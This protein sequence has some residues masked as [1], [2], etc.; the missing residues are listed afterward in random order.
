MSRLIYTD[1]QR[2]R[3]LLP[4]LFNRM[5][6]RNCSY[7][8]RKLFMSLSFLF[9]TSQIF[10]HGVQTAWCF[11]PNGD[12]IRIYIEHWH[13]PGQNVDCSAG[14]TIDVSVSINGGAATVYNNLS[15]NSNIPGTLATLPHEPNLPIKVIST[16][17][18]ANAYNNWGS[19]DFPIPAG[20]C[21]QGG[22]INITVLSA[23]DCVFEEVCGNLYPASTN[24]IITPA[25]CPCGPELCDGLDNDCDGFIDEGFDLDGDGFTTCQND[26]NDDN[27]SINP[28]ATEICDGID[29]NCDGFIDEGFTDTDG[30]SMAD[31]VDPDDDN[32]GTLDNLDCYP[33]DPIFPGT[34]GA[35]CNDGNT[36]TVNDVFSANGCSCTGTP[37]GL[38]EDFALFTTTG[39]V[40]NAGT[41]TVNGHVGANVGAISGFGLP[42]TLNGNV[43]SGDPATAQASIDVQFLYDQLLLT[44]PALAHPATYG[45]G[46]TVFPGTYAVASAG[47]LAGTI[48][49]N[50]LG[51]PD[52]VF[53]FKFGGA[54]TIGASSNVILSNGAQPCNV[55]WL[56]AGA[57]SIG[58]STQM[59]G[60]FISSPGAIT[61]ATGGILDGR[62]LSTTGAIA[63]SNA[64]VLAPCVPA[65][66]GT[67][68]DDGNPSTG[69]DVEDGFGNC[70][71]TQCPAAGATC[72]DGDAST[73]D[74]VE[75]G[76]CN[77]AGI[78]SLSPNL[79]TMANFALFTSTGALSNAGTSN[80]WGDVGTNAGAVAGFGAPTVLGGVIHAANATTAAGVIDLQNLS[81]QLLAAPSTMVHAPAFGAGE[82]LAPGVY[83]TA[84][85]GSVGGNLTLDGQG[86]SDA[87]FVF[88][89]GGAFTTGASATVMLIDGAQSCNVY[90]ISVGAIAM[91]TNTTMVGTIISG[92]GA[93]SMAVGGILEGRLLTTSGAIAVSGA[94]ITNNCINNNNNN[95]N[96]AVPNMLYFHALKNGIHTDID[97]MMAKDENVDFYEVEV[98]TDGNTF[99]VMEETNSERVNSPRQYELVDM[100][101]V[102]GENYYRLKVNQ[103]DGTYFYSSIRKVNFD[104]DFDNVILYPN[105][106][107]ENIYID[108][109]DF[110]GKTGLVEIFNGLG[111][112]MTERNY[113]SFPSAPAVFKVNDFTNGMYTVSIK[114]ENY[115]RIIKKFVVNKL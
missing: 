94:N 61:M 22:S 15:F 40:S 88:K 14:A 103:L 113:L 46:E 105:P 109:R 26:C 44:T 51:D 6:K 55:F 84:G 102:Y 111:Q 106:T 90:W 96:F 31:C 4:K 13:G 42:S 21:P 2:T 68:C 33:T 47:S 79:G 110:A 63:I 9:L 56:S 108:M 75:D 52:A 112:K 74:D 54:Y 37:L 92:P 48:T 35:T 115:K 95:N 45:S 57:I 81:N 89:F 32:D 85:A 8:L 10:A 20:L 104:I 50:A 83:A 17:S 29:N 98:S 62:L 91:A 65:P 66:A 11:A 67:P 28:G 38:L 99:A 30:D 70:A 34:P 53:I 27:A 41:S 36:N 101:P 7:Y 72:D 78:Y 73:A 69:N 58:A 80:I 43:H 12:D 23:N 1:Q 76:N 71:G 18:Q 60:T 97:W 3:R 86:D 114:V 77:C 93:V 5:E 24:T 59:K 82:I 39:A 25:N 107:H 49:L 16:C 100:N 19:W 87:V 64:L